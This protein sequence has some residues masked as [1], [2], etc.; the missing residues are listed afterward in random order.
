MKKKICLSLGI[1]LV[2]ILVGGSIWSIKR[3]IKRQEEKIE[4]QEKQVADIFQRFT[5][6]ANT[7]NEKVILYQNKISKI[8]F[9]SFATESKNY[10]SLLEELTTA[11]LHM[12]EEVQE[13]KPL[14]DDLPS[15]RKQNCDSMQISLASAFPIYHK[16]VED[17]NG[18]VFDYNAWQKENTK[19]KT[20]E[21]YAGV[22]EGIYE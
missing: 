9:T 19:Y 8:Y 22:Q 3:Q 20:V 4:I 15:E 16:L 14:C 2:S 12:K 7:F 13:S 11:I 10:V 5:S 6:V 21:P 17:Y 18:L 1:F